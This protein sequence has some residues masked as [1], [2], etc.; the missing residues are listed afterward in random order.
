MSPCVASSRD[1]QKTSN[2]SV[3]LWSC[4]I[5]LQPAFPLPPLPLPLPL[6]LPP[7]LPLLS[8]PLLPPLP[9][10]PPPPPP[11]LTPPLDVPR[12]LLV[13]GA[14]PRARGTPAAWLCALQYE[15][16]SES[17][18]R[19]ARRFGRSTASSC[20][21]GIWSKPSWLECGGPTLATWWIGSGGGVSYRGERQFQVEAFKT[22]VGG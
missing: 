12:A 22:W 6:P 4:E 14:V 16:H 3:R 7:L 2:L 5:E 10:P 8:P 21:H 15:P 18:S 11:L 17:S 9:P 19:L 20:T 13:V 1:T